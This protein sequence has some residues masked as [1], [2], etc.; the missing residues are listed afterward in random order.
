[1][2]SAPGFLLAFLYASEKLRWSILFLLFCRKF[3]L[4]LLWCQG[5]CTVL[6][7]FKTCFIR[8]DVSFYLLL[9]TN[10]YDFRCLLLVDISVGDQVSSL[11]SVI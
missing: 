9:F 5:I 8:F 1:M 2:F 10:I 6:Y 3:Q 7:L 11:S 4:W